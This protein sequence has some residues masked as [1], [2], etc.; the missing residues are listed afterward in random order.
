MLNRKHKILALFLV[1]VFLM[2]TGAPA[3]G[4]DQGGGKADRYTN[5]AAGKGKSYKFVG[6]K[7]TKEYHWPVCKYAKSIKPQDR[8]YFKTAREAQ[9]AGYVHCRVCRRFRF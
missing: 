5:P 2:V 8:I 1:A 7:K 6:S 4:Q 3:F 9:A